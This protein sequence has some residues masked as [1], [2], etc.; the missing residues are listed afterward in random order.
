LLNC[1]IRPIFFP[2]LS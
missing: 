1:Y 2:L